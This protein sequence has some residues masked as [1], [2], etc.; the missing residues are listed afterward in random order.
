MASFVA[1]D[2]LLCGMA[3]Q[4]KTQH[5]SLHEYHTET[6]AQA[7]NDSDTSTGEIFKME[8]IVGTKEEQSN[9]RQ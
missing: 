4:N 8:N 7:R 1:L 6:L 5:S 3:C 9:G 2:V